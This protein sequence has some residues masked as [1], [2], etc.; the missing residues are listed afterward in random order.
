MAKVAIIDDDVDIIDAVSLVLQSKGFSVVSAK[1]ANDGLKLVESESPDI[2]LLDVMMEEPDDGFYFAMKL[3]KMGIKTPIFLLTSI[4]K[5]T[6]FD[7]A[8]SESL[9]VE[10]FLEKPL[11]SDV[12]IEKIN[13]YLGQK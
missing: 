3:R 13:K 8:G 12:L 11:Q 4:S 9:P 7:Y 5:V 2:I 1:N 6:G 10:E